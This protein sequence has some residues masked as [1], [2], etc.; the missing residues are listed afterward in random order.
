MVAVAREIWKV[1]P[2]ANIEFWTDKKYYKN[3]RKIT[4]ENGLDLTIKK[5]FA[6]KLRRYTNFTFITYLQHFDVVL[7]NI[8]DFFKIFAG[9]FQSFWRL[10]INRP[11]VIFLKGGYV[12]LPVG[13]SVDFKDSV[14]NPR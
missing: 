12:C 6:G 14:R 9:F 7:K 10:L 11:N 2:R 8:A 4:V 13:G 5:V 1:R 3:A